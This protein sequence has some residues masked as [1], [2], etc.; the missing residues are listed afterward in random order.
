MQ[1][2]YFSAAWHDIK[3]SPGW[4]GKLV[5]LSLISLIPIFGWIV[6]AGYL[7]GWARDIAWNVHSPLPKHI[8]GNEDGKLYSRGFFVLVIGFVC[9]LAPWVLEVVWGVVTGVGTAWSGRSHGGIFLAVGLS[10]TIF[11]LVIM[12]AA[13]FATLFSWVGSMRMSVYGRLGAGFQF[14]KIW[15]MMR[16]DF[17]GLVRILG[18]VILLSIGIGIIA[19]ILMFFIILIGLF[20][21]F[22]M[23]GGNMNL[24]AS[25]PDAA[26]WGVIA[27]TSGVVLV[28]VALYCVLAMVMSV[29]VEMMLVRA[30]G[31][32]TRQFDVPSWRGQDDPMPFEFAQP[33]T[34]QPPYG[35]PPMQG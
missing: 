22:M 4:F 18:M 32:W 15:A 20:V 2:G 12:A 5:L 3:N 21:G 26:V 29:F 17:G 10:T 23:T 13:F 8:F 1:T 31:Y 14:N 11:S 7:Y 9:M 16:H 33:P 19:S 27:A 35:Q 30:L 24:Q 25:H 34:Q 28:L 6:V